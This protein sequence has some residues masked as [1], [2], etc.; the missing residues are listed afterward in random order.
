VDNSELINRLYPLKGWC[1]HISNVFV[2]YVHVENSMLSEVVEDIRNMERDRAL[3]AVKYSSLLPARPYNP[4]EEFDSK[5]VFENFREDVQNN[6]YEGFNLDGGILNN[7]LISPFITN[8]V[9]KLLIIGLWHTYTAPEYIYDYYDRQNVIVL[10]PDIVINP[11]DTLRFEGSYCRDMYQ[12]G[13]N[14]AC[15]VL[16]VLK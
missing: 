4:D 14:A 11:G 6:V 9:D 15:G 13:R 5:R 3:S 7:S 16:E 10:R 8:K 12:R 2:N 1:S